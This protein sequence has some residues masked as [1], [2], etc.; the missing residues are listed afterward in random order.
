[1]A[2][3]AK[4]GSLKI[5]TLNEGPLHAGL[6]EWYARPGDRC[7][8]EVDGFLVDVVRGNLL[9]EIQTA[10]FTSI[11]RKLRA[12]AAEHPVLLV[13]PLPQDKWIVR[14][15]EDGET[16]LGRRRSPKHAAVEHVF[17]ELVRLPELM[18]NPRFSLEVVL[19]QEEEVRRHAPGRAWRR[20]GWVTVERRLLKVV[21]TRLF[22][23][24]EDMM[25]L[26]PPSL[27]E[28]F[29]TADLAAAAGQPRRLAQKMAYCLRTM[30]AIKQVGK[31]GN[32]LLY[33]RAA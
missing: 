31:S 23:G 28:P 30:N 2:K 12:L 19:I 15:G 13:Y 5:A 25:E 10:N 26:V 11:R 6:K 33:T 1:M 4:N 3:D 7:E 24:P 18:A 9:I 14:L 20:K 8:V 16:V 32:A 22:E 27:P 21:G 17:D 29:T